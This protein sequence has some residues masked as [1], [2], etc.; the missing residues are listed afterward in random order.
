MIKF[1]FP[2]HAAK[3][4]DLGQEMA[5]AVALDLEQSGYRE[6]RTGQHVSAYVLNPVNQVT[7][8]LLKKQFG[9]SARAGKAVHDKLAFMGTVVS[10]LK[11]VEQSYQQRLLA[12]TV[13]TIRLQNHSGTPA[14]TEIDMIMVCRQGGK[15]S[16]WVKPHANELYSNCHHLFSD[17][18]MLPCKQAGETPSNWVKVGK[19]VDGGFEFASA[20]LEQEFKQS[21]TVDDYFNERDAFSS[22]DKLSLFFCGAYDEP[23]FVGVKF[24][25]QATLDKFTALFPEIVAYAQQFENKTA[26]DLVKLMNFHRK[27]SKARERLPFLPYKEY[28]AWES[29]T[30]RFALW[31]LFFDGKLLHHT[32]SHE[33]ILAL[34][35]QAQHLQKLLQYESQQWDICCCVL[36]IAKCGMEKHQ[37]LAKAGFTVNQSVFVDDKG[38]HYLLT[39]FNVKPYGEQL[40]FTRLLKGGKLSKVGSSKQLMWRDIEQG[41][42][43]RLAPQQQMIA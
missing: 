31:Y 20:A 36:N 23:C 28:W 13:S 7:T 14:D 30:F 39:G 12:H 27:L 11:N 34:L 4:S 5:Q 26:V 6:A 22:L 17:G 1:P 8:G 15:V 10:Y 24:A 33:D 29:Y 21:P 18:V 37:K 43:L 41:R 2:I 40:E 35:T 9:F 25:N 38:I 3:L 42:Y 19:V 16:Y 32:Y